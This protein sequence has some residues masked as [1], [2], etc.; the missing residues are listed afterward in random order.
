MIKNISIAFVI[1]FCIGCTSAKKATIPFAKNIKDSLKAE[2]E[3]VYGQNQFSGFSVAIVN[4]KNILY[5]QGIGYADVQSK[6]PYTHHS[7]QNIASVSKTLIGISLLKAQELGKLKLTD[8]I[9][10]YLPFKVYNPAW[11]AA[12]ITIEQL[13]NH[14]SG[15][16]DNAT[17]LSRSYVLK[18]NQN[19]AHLLVSIDEEQVFNA[20]DSAMSL[21]DFLRNYLSPRGRFYQTDCFTQNKPGEIFEYSNIGSALAAYIIECAT[22]TKFDAFTRRYILSPLKMTASGWHF[23]DVKFS[24]YSTLYYNPD[25][26]IAYYSIITYPDGNFITSANDLAK[27][28][29]ELMRGYEGNG[30]LLTAKSYRQLFTP[31]LGAANFIDRNDKNPYSESYNYSVF[32]GFSM[33]GNIGHSGGDPGVSSLLSFNPDTK[34][35]RLMIINTSINNQQGNKEFYNIWDKLEKYQYKLQGY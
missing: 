33:V 21:A 25:T 26:A 14:T 31:K 10:H 32:I 7:I 3:D 20:P 30:R 23:N 1:I 22:G 9:N 4:S 12:E 13:A 6:K 29:Q 8:P 24:D 5:E 17:Y 16:M 15:I 11:P 18:P 35:G 28:L 2:L 34:I 27:F 19:L